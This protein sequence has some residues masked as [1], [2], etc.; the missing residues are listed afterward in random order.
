[1][2]VVSLVSLTDEEGQKLLREC[3]YGGLLPY[4][5][6]QVNL[7]YCGLC[8]VAICLNE[9]LENYAQND[10]INHGKFAELAQVKDTR[11]TLQEDDIL[12]IGEDSLLFR[13]ED[14]NKEGI[15]LQTFAS[16]INIIGLQATYFHVFPPSQNTSKLLNPTD[17]NSS[18]ISSADEFRSIALE[19][20][21]KLGGQVVVN[22]F[23]ADFYPDLNFGHF[24][25][26]GGYHVAE[27]MF[28]LL[29]VWPGNPV[30]WVKT[31]H[32]FNAM[33]TQDSSSCLPRGFCVFNIE[34]SQQEKL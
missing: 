31:Q 30:G 28:L 9:I 16:L 23:L 6:K 10:V 17:K 27:D 14:V 12:K 22:Y 24:S 13:R 25:P 21:Q 11:T 19:N 7:T 8:S 18:G 1:M 29:D 5:C 32:L 33:V 20:L 4:F 2:A 3:Q 15:T 26:L 34:N